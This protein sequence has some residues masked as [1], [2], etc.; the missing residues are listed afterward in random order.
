[1]IGLVLSMVLS[2]GTLKGDLCIWDTRVNPPEWLCTGYCHLPG[3]RDGG[4]CRRAVS[5]RARPGQVPDKSSET[6]EEARRRAMADLQRQCDAAPPP[7]GG[8]LER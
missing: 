6:R 1:M 2:S 8:C 7:P 5:A 4:A 3:N